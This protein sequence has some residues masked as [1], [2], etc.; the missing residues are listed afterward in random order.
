MILLVTYDLNAP[1]KDYEELYKTLKT[2]SSWWHYL[3]S[4]WLLYTSTPYGTWCDNIRK[5]IDENDHFMVVD[6]TK[7]PRNGWLPKKAWEWIRSHEKL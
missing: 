5:V 4:T 2:A 1:S 3:D 6:I 7:Q